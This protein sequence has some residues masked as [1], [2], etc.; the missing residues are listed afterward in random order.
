MHHL[1]EAN[2]ATMALPQR[3]GLNMRIVMDYC[4]Y[5]SLQDY[6]KQPGAVGSKPVVP[7]HIARGGSMEQTLCALMTT[8]DI[9]RGLRLLHKYHVIH[10][11]LKPHNV[12]VSRA[13][14]VRVL[15]LRTP[16]C[17]PPERPALCRTRAASWRR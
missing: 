11:D 10:G 1:L 13:T 8:L 9:A 17:Q 2:P 14:D 12:L 6:L 15:L 16:H 4:E 7:L 5:G 3:V